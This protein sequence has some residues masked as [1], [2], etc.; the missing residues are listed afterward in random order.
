[1][2]AEIPLAQDMALADMALADRIHAKDG[3][4][5]LLQDGRCAWFTAYLR[6]VTLML[7]P[8]SKF[9]TCFVKPVAQ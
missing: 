8:S 9:A 6:G 3:R 7:E 2:Q 4:L 5:R 1:M